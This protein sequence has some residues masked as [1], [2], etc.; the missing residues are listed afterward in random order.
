[1]PLIDLELPIDAAPV[2][3]DVRAFLHEASRRVR[4]FCKGHHIPGF[5]ASDF[6]AVYRSLRALAE[7]DLA[8]GELFCEWGS[9]LGV[10]AC[11]ASQLGFDARGIEVEPDL[12][13][14]ARQ[15]ADD[16]ELPVEFAQGS[17]IP[18]GRLHLLG[19]TDGF[20]WLT[21]AEDGAH[22]ELGLAPDEYGV[23]FAYPWPDEEWAVQVLFEN[24]ASSDALLMT[25]HGLGRPRLRRKT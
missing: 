1:L 22:E 16:F 19:P 13:D 6:D 11:L 10:V 24:C 18:G 14:A 5:V 7:A 20:A 2:P 15:L 12:V 8:P 25:Y 4:R 21:S 9:G 3:A 17:F 23:V